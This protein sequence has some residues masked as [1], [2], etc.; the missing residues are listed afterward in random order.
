MIKHKLE[1]S[2]SVKSFTK[3]ESYKDKTLELISTSKYKS[4]NVAKAE[5]NIT[6]TDWDFSRTDREWLSYIQ[7]TLMSEVF[8]IYDNM[9]YSGF[10]VNEI[11]F[12][13]YLQESEH[14]WHIHSGNFTNVY[15]LEL[16]EGTPKTQIINPYNQKDIIE[17]DVKEGDLLTFPSYVLHKAP[18]NNSDKRKTIISFNTDVF[19]DD[20]IYG[21]NLLKE[22]KD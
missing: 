16:P 21:H 8:D 20:E 18:K 6:K 14:G 22:K 9:G 7:E 3:H 13:Q 12:Q 15:Y 10:K 19:Y 4:P 1:S 17:V 11:W 5:V 2:Y